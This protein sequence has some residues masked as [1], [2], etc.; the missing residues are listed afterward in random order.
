MLTVMSLSLYRTVDLLF[1]FVQNVEIQY[2]FLVPIFSVEFFI[3]IF[4]DTMTLSSNSH[5]SGNRLIEAI[6]CFRKKIK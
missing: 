2:F 1:F 6:E 4:S 3:E 5:L